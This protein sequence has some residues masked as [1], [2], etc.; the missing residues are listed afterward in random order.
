MRATSSTPLRDFMKQIVR[1]PSRVS[2][3]TSSA[4]SARTLRRVCSTSSSTRRVPH[5]DLAPRAGRGVL[6]DELHVVEAR[7]GARPARPGWRSSRSRAGSAASCRRPARRAAAGAARWRRGCRRR[8]GRR[9][10]RRRRRRRGSRTG[11]PSFAWWGSTP[12]WS[13]SGLVRMR[14]ERRRICRALLARRVAVVDRG[15]DL[16]VQ[17]EPVQRARLVLR[18]RLRRVEVE[19]AGVRVGEQRLERREL[20]AE[21]L[22]RRGPRG[23]DRRARP[24]RVERLRLMRVQLLDPGGR[25]RLAQPGVQVTGNR[26]ERRLAR[27]LERLADEPPVGAAVL[28]D[29]GPRLGLTDGGHPGRCYSRPGYPRQR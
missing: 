21:R 17:P 19:R 14:F 11:R 6:V 12:M 23:D 3:A 7:R 26:C 1:E 16:L 2:R 28:Q 15:A 4:A 13:M 10:P 29:A 18:E 9:A 24:R 22:A 27:P 20:E 5:R 25:E 8:R